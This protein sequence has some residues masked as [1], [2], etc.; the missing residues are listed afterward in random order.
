M[1]TNW[2]VVTFFI[3]V[4]GLALLA[5]AKRQRDIPALVVGAALLFFPYF[6]SSVL[7]CLVIAGALLAAF[8]LAKV[9]HVGGS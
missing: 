9:Y 6:V 2:L 7:W 1:S 4:A 3:S 8:I 5:Y